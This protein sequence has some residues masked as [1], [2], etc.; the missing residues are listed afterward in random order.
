MITYQIANDQLYTDTINYNIHYTCW[1]IIK[2]IFN[3]SQID[4]FLYAL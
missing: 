3:F 2:Q 1:L 4:L